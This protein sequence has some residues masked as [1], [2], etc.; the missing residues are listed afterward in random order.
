M[1]L[2]PRGRVR[3]LS[4]V[5]VAGLAMAAC[6]PGTPTGNPS[7]PGASTP[8]GSSPAATAAGPTA[9]TGG[10]AFVLMTTAT[11][12]GD[13][14]TDMDPQRVYIGEDIAFF[15]ATIMLSLTGYKYSADQ[16]E[17]TSLVPDAATDVGTPSDG[18]KTW[19]FTLRD[20][21]KW[22]DGSAVKCEDF[23]YGVSR[24]Y[25]TSV[26]INGPQY[27]IGY[28]DIPTV[29]VY[30]K[31]K[32][33]K[34]TKST[35]SAYGGP[36][37]DAL[38][39]VF[40]DAAATKTI[41]NDKAAFDKAVTCDGNKITYHLNKPV[42][43]FNY[44]VTLG[45]SAVPNPTD[46]PGVDNGAQYSIKPWSNGPYMID[47]YTPGVGGNLT[48]VRNP[49]WD[50][51]MDGGY[52]GAY[53]DKWVVLF[54][55]D[56][57]VA[58]QR[59]IAPQGDDSFALGYGNVQTQNLGQVFSDS[60][61]AASGF[62]G[63]AFSDLDP[64]VSYWW[65][66]VNKVKNEKI[67]QAIAVAIDR[68]AIRATSGGDFYGDAGD[69]LVKPNI[70]QDYAPTGFATDLF[71]EAVG[72]NGNPTLAKKLIADSGE[73]APALTYDYGKSA[74][75]DQRAAIIKSSLEAVGFTITLNPIQSGYY[76]T[77]ADPKL[78]HE[79]G[80]S[81]WGADW[82]NASTVI[83][84]LLTGATQFNDASDY[85]QITKENNPDFY[86]AFD[87]AIS[88]TDRAAQATAWQN[89]NKMSVQKAWIVPNTFTL[90]QVIAGD[91][92]TTAQ[93]L[94]KWPAY[95]S[96]PYAQIYVQQ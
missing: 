21:I 62:T 74:T 3:A 85:P 90:S 35:T 36:Y 48:L 76:A 41:P 52:R 13:K 51:A 26:I 19:S 2:G 16:K 30:V 9:T 6:S 94:Y 84:P 7:A 11:S 58:D 31:D 86:A 28:L 82:P 37:A 12:N 59:L 93:G 18:A 17:G 89:L 80:T 81:G 10:T 38:V 8:A 56:P 55:L 95:G 43:D 70:G 25:A 47:S 88:N 46:H 63:R 66:N 54:G 75:G 61:T 4:F 23:K 14:Y 32:D 39:G 72:P 83:G 65:I 68:E 27:A 53:P 29:D 57:T 78:Q 77:I 44:T 69:G 22:Q 92:I 20:G 64:Y 49:N 40:S 87:A 45:M 33:G 5:V 42:A 60:H 67:R 1:S 79:F 24:T 50:T 34:I 15:G 91:K 96:W 71:G 73:A